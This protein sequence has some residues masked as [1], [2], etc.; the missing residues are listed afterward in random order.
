MSLT[1]EQ[2]STA[3]DP[4]RM[5]VLLQDSVPASELR[6]FCS[7]CCRR[8]YQKHWPH[9]GELGEALRTAEAFAA[10]QASSEQLRAAHLNAARLLEDAVNDFAF[11]N[12][13]LGDSTDGWDYEAAFH[14]RYVAQ[15]IAEVTEEDIVYSAVR[16]IES[17]A[18]VM[19]F[20][21][22]VDGETWNDDPRSP[23]VL[24]EEAVQA[25][26]IRDRWPYPGAEAASN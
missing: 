25:Q 17:A 1:Q 19:G 9:D 24:A 18:R 2:W 10:G 22:S 20:S 15:A 23:G 7:A 5:L 11:V 26:M 14:A 4:L 16:C 21:R 12:M 3:T 13:K 6:G 8:V